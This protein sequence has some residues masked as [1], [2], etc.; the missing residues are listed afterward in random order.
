MRQS[1]GHKTNKLQ[2]RSNQMMATH[3]LS[4]L[5][6]ALL[7]LYVSF[8]GDSTLIYIPI[9]SSMTRKQKY[10]YYGP[11]IHLSLVTR[12]WYTDSESQT[13]DVLARVKLQASSLKS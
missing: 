12:T 4:P 13:R 7:Q 8:F 10:R 2:L 1:T 5:T 3:P 6:L 9:C 11:I